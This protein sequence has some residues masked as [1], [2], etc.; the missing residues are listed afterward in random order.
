MIVAAAT[1]KTPQ[2]LKSKPAPAK[3]EAAP[4]T[5]VKDWTVVMYLDGDNDAEERISRALPLLEQKAG[6]TD[7]VN[8]VAQLGRLPQEK[9][10][11]IYKD[12]NYDYQ[13]TAIDG[14]WSGVRRF[15]VTKQEATPEG[16]GQIRSECTEKLSPDVHMADSTTIADCLIDAFKKYPAKNYAVCFADHGGSILGAMTSDGTP[17]ASGHDIINPAQLNKSLEL[18]EKAT[19]VKPNVIDFAACLMASGEVASQLSDRADYYL[20]SQE[21]TSKTYQ[22]YGSI[23]T[24]LTQASADGKPMTPKEFG[25]RVLH[26]YDNKPKVAPDKSMIDLSKM[27]ELKSAVSDMVSALK[28][29][30][31]E[32][33]KLA[34]AIAE[35]QHFGLHSDPITSFSAQ[36]RD[37]RGFAEKLE[38]LARTEKD[39]ALSKAAG[40]VAEAV[41]DAVVDNHAHDY[42]R[43]EVLF[44]GKSADGKETATTIVR[45][46]G[47]Y[48]AHGISL[49]TPLNSL[50]TTPEKFGAFVENRYKYLSFAQETGWADWLLDFNAQLSADKVAAEAAKKDDMP[51]Y[52]PITPEL[53]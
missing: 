2:V 36:T 50:N 19:G 9:L 37:L 18:V 44:T 34:E 51:E 16:R 22:H 14:D 15:Y 32:A 49:F 8:I 7:K 40:A 21:V 38:S 10:A 13:P 11:K 41:A 12:R 17:S 24:D 26:E 29:T 20:A 53:R 46:D 1:P 47:H 31:I 4:E 30:K 5:P 48:D 6:S 25:L 43:E 27:G 52:Q 3:A 23:L 45:Y 33:S 42:S 39:R 28:K 35:A